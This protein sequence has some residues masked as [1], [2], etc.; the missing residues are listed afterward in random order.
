MAAWT[1]MPWVVSKDVTSV[2]YWVVR[3]V[4]YWAASRD[5]MTAVTM[6]AYWVGWK[7]ASMDAM[8]AVAKGVM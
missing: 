6:D 4:V 1:D 8:L 2:A 3:S 7:V 5:E